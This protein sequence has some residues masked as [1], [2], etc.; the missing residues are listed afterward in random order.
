MYVTMCMFIANSH[1]ALMF[2]VWSL[3]E[4]YQIMKAFSF[5]SLNQFRVSFAQDFWPG[6]V[7]PRSSAS[8]MKLCWWIS[9]FK[10]HDRHVQLK[11]LNAWTATWFC[12]FGAEL[13]CRREFSWKTSDIRTLVHLENKVGEKRAEIR[14]QFLRKS[15]RFE[16]WSCQSFYEVLTNG[17]V[18]EPPF[19]ARIMLELSFD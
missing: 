15:L 6:L 9:E 7:S 17:W 5:R 3:C 11:S 13:M 4:N 12:A 8:Q 14:G 10:C 2:K 16:I 18:A 1:E 19:H